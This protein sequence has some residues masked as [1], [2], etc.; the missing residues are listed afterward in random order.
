MDKDLS[1]VV[2]EQRQ[3][4]RTKAKESK[5]KQAK[6]KKGAAGFRR[7]KGER[8]RPTDIKRR[9]V[10][11]K[12]SEGGDWRDNPSKDPSQLRVLN[13]G[14]SVTESEIKVRNIDSR[15]SL[16][17]LESWT[18][19]RSSGHEAANLRARQWSNF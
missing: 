3:A 5:K 8:R 10:K 2:K 7:S 12:A 14:Y 19:Q 6:S 11:R 9:I 4:N 18:S 17:P 16:E 13:L 15:S 1:E